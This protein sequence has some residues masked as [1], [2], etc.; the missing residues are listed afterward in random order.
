M[1]AAIHWH[2]H[3]HWLQH[4]KKI[5][6]WGRDHDNPLGWLGWTFTTQVNSLERHQWIHDNLGQPNNSGHTIPI[7][8]WLDNGRY[9][10]FCRDISTHMDQL[11][12]AICSARKLAHSQKIPRWANESDTKAQHLH[13]RQVRKMSIQLWP[14]LLVITGFK[15]DNKQSING[16]IS[17]Y[18][19]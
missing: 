19:W 6:S 2:F 9:P 17:T 1:P 3:K 16:V 14:W 7:R 13:L 10:S 18:N 5:R 12:F 15:W 4:C 11:G 8:S